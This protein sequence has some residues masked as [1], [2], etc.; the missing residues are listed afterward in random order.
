MRIG[1]IVFIRTHFKKRV[2]NEN[3]PVAEQ[4]HEIEVEKIDR[5]AYYYSKAIS[6]ENL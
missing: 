5:E 3:N 1:Y 4:R 2:Y 6:S